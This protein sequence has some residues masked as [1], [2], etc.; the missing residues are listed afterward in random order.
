MCAWSRWAGVCVSVGSRQR[1]PPTPWEACAV[2]VMG[3]TVTSQ[4]P[5]RWLPSRASVSLR[6]YRSRFSVGVFCGGSQPRRVL[7]IST[8]SPSRERV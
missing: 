8:S 1:G 6:V 3:F 2:E 7:S 5:W 4:K